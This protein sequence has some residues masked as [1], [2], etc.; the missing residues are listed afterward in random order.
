VSGAVSVDVTLSSPAGA[1][2]SIDPSRTFDVTATPSPLRVTQATVMVRSAQ[3]RQTT[4]ADLDLSSAIGDR[5]Q[6]GRLLL[7]VKDPFA[8]RGA[9][10]VR[11]TAPGVSLA[12]SLDVAGGD[13]GYAIEFT[14]DE[15]RSLIG[16]TVAIE[17]AGPVSVSG[18]V[19][20]TPAQTIGIA[21]RFE[22]VIN[23]T[24]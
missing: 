22:L 14:H 6:S 18:P 15:L 10:A 11:L 1:P 8:V 21:T 2:T 19:T 23:S 20:V 17:I 7:T 5:V 4:S 3:V 16:H 24:N 12:K 13:R 9:L